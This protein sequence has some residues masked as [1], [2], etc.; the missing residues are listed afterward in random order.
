MGIIQLR[1]KGIS[2]KFERPD[3]EI[4]KLFQQLSGGGIVEGTSTQLKLYPTEQTVDTP[5]STSETQNIAYY[6][7]S[8]SE[9]I[10]YI[11]TLPNYKHSVKSIISHFNNQEIELDRKNELLYLYWFNIRQKAKNARIKIEK[12]ESGKW[13]EVRVSKGKEYRFEKT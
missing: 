9:T 11:K 1:L 7:P 8:T 5:K 12:N 6:R 13:I 2:I 10:E 3:E 4:N